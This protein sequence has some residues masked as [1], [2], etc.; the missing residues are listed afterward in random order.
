MDI[1]STLRLYEKGL[2]TKSETLLR[3]CQTAVDY[4]PAEIAPA[5]PLEWLSEIKV[6]ALEE[7]DSR[8]IIA[9][10]FSSG[11]DEAYCDAESKRFNHGRHRWREFFS[12]QPTSN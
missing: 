4:D 7:N 8:V 12:S 11:G 3:I 2:T 9:G 6:I 5:L 1:S 10:T